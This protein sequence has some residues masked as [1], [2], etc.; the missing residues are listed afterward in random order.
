MVRYARTPWHAFW[1]WRHGYPVVCIHLSHR[2]RLPCLRWL[3]YDGYCQKHNATCFNDDSGMC[4]R[5]ITVAP[6]VAPAES[7][8]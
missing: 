1:R 5:S 7:G 2:L 6:D 3:A 8:G 4:T